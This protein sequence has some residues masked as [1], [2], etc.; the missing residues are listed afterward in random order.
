MGNI[1]QVP[2]KYRAISMNNARH[3]FYWPP[4][5]GSNK[6]YLQL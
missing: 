6:L 4:V 3:A 1:L 2:R 5:S